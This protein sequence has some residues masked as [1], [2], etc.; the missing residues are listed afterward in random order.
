MTHK[1]RFVK[2]NPQFLFLVYSTKVTHF[3]NGLHCVKS[4]GTPTLKI[5]RTSAR[6][7]RARYRLPLSFLRGSMCSITEADSSCVS[8]VVRVEGAFSPLEAS[9]LIFGEVR[10][11]GGL[12]GVFLVAMPQS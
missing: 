3:S 12:G 10:D 11:A 5:Q 6:M 1:C 7:A 2:I 4:D 8:L 9:F